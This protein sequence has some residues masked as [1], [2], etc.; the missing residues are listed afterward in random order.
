LR[1]VPHERGAPRGIKM[2]HRFSQILTDFS[3]YLCPSVFIRV[4]F[5]GQA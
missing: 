1:T 3:L 2:G 5:S 4:P